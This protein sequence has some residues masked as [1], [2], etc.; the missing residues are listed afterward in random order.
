LIIAG[1][2]GLAVVAFLVD[3]FLLNEPAKAS[4]APPS[5]TTSRKATDAKVAGKNDNSVTGLQMDQALDWLNRMPEPEKVRDAFSLAEP[6]LAERRV[7]KER[8]RKAETVVSQPAEDLS[9]T[10]IA[11]HRLQTTLVDPQGG[12]AV[13]DGRVLRIGDEIDGFQLKTVMADQCVFTEISSKEA[14]TLSLERIPEP[15]AR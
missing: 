11:Q 3:R 15:K 9:K 4:D 7:A 5:R 2:L 10:F 1:F 13:V 6:F 8:E 12:I 14:F